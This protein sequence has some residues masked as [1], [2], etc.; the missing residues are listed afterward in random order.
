MLIHELGLCMRLHKLHPAEELLTHVCRA[1]Q[2]SNMVGIV[3]QLWE[4]MGLQLP[5]VKGSHGNEV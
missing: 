2:G 4:G 5:E 3:S 1:K